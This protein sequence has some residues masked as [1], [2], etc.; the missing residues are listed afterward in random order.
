MA[1]P[2]PVLLLTGPVGAGKSTV[3]D[4]AA[5]LT[6]RLGGLRLLVRDL[7]SEWYSRGRVSCL[8]D[9]A[10]RRAEAI[11]V[12]RAQPVAGARAR[13]WWIRT[14]IAAFARQ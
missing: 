2:V 12:D 7:A 1:P 13:R 11:E 14:R 6:V 9:H 10:H 3:A 5:R 8:G 4:E